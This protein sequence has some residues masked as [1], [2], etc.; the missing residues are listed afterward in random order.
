MT[1]AVSALKSQQSWRNPD[2]SASH[3]PRPLLLG[4]SWGLERGKR[5]G[6]ISRRIQCVCLWLGARNFLLWE[7]RV[8]VR[9]LKAPG[10]VSQ[11]TRCR[12]CAV[13][14]GRN[15]R[16]GGYSPQILLTFFVMVAYN[17]LRLAGTALQQL[18]RIA[19]R[20]VT[21]SC[22][23]GGYSRRIH[24]AFRRIFCSVL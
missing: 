12:L 18:Q 24:C 1:I 7:L 22:K 4:Y 20:D 14:R 21:F 6:G 3:P 19:N 11:P 10:Y 16:T 17:C 2:R 9:C 15:E 8:C 5:D 13:L 23:H